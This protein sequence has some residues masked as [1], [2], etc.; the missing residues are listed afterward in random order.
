MI[1][2]SKELLDKVL[3]VEILKYDVRHTSIHYDYFKDGITCTSFNISKYELAH[4]CKEWALSKNIKIY[5]LLVKD[6]GKCNIHKAQKDE[7]IIDKTFRAESE[8]ESIIKA[9]E[10]ILK[11]LKK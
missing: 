3:N 2:I 11:E 8:P 10:W 1:E 7:K 6:G 5:S 4:K 9:C